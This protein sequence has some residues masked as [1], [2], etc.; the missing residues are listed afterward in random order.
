MIVGGVCAPDDRLPVITLAAELG[1]NGSSAA[2]RIRTTGQV[3]IEPD[4]ARSLGERIARSSPRACTKR[5]HSALVVQPRAR[6]S[7]SALLKLRAGVSGDFHQ[8]AAGRPAD[9]SD[10]GDRRRKRTAA[11]GA[12]TARTG[13]ARIRE[14]ALAA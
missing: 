5:A 9:R 11:S 1:G 3:V 8:R 14:E 4:L 10:R 6:R 13:A 7:M 2:C 12:G